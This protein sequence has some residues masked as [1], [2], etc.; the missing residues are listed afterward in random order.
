[1]FSTRV[2]MFSR[3]LTPKPL[4]P[5]RRADR[6]HHHGMQDVRAGGYSA[7]L[8]LLTTHKTQLQY[9]TTRQDGAI[10][11]TVRDMAER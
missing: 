11:L 8:S 4:W 3:C 7:A 9:E 10:P 6:Q 1:M 5:A 2:R